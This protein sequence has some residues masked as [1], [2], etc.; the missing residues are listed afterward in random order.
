MRTFY[1]FSWTFK[2]N[3]NLTQFSID[4]FSMW[5]AISF[6]RSAKGKTLQNWLRRMLLII[7][8]PEAV[9][10]PLVR[11]RGP[12]RWPDI[13][14]LS[15]KQKKKAWSDLF[16]IDSHILIVPLSS[17]W[18]ISIWLSISWIR[19]LDI[20]LLRSFSLFL[21]I[22]F[23]CLLNLDSLVEY[24]DRRDTYSLHISND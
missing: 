21:M 8:G 9:R 13:E 18:L 24:F 10:V 20:D 5:L 7:S 14:P 1:F 23:L 11:R 4:I 3:I 17:M 2:H 22:T 19:R 12:I 16:L 6:H 15:A